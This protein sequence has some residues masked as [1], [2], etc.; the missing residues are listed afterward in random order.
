MVF[1]RQ[2]LEN[3]V[4]TIGWHET[5]RICQA[6]SDYRTTLL[7]SLSVAQR[8]YNWAQWTVYGMHCIVLLGIPWISMGFWR[9]WGCHLTQSFRDPGWLMLKQ[10]RSTW[11]VS[12]VSIQG[13]CFDS[14]AESG[15]DSTVSVTADPLVQGCSKQLQVYH[16]HKGGL[17]VLLPLHLPSLHRFTLSYLRCWQQPCC[18]WF[19]C[20]IPVRKWWFLRG[21]LAFRISRGIFA[22]SCNVSAELFQHGK[23]ILHPVPYI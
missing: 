2:S 3:L 5:L 19:S 11:N 17:L 18:R 22:S 21:A 13:S 8:S 6:I 16:S 7:R 9:Y 15:Y 1:T 4:E 12:S 14:S 23:S 20:D 10:T